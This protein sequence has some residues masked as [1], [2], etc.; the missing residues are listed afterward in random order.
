MNKDHLKIANWSAD[1][2][3]TIGGDDFFV[4]IVDQFR[5]IA[6]FDFCLI[7]LYQKNKP[8]KVIFDGLTP[9]GCADG[10]RNFVEN[11]YV[12]NPFYKAFS[13]G[14]DAGLHYMDE[15][16][17]GNDIYEGEHG[18]YK[19]TIDSAEEIGYVTRGWPK[20]MKEILISIPLDDN[21]MVEVTLAQKKDVADTGE[22]VLSELENLI[23]LLIS[24]VKKHCEIKPVTNQAANSAT[25]SLSTREK[26]VAELILAGHSSLS[27][28]NHLGIALP[29]VKTHRKN[30]YQKLEISTQAELFSIYYQK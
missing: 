8:P 11:T 28:G 13:K 7:F 9:I 20:H 21:S 2:V 29:T 30:I 17:N 22:R 1:F 24:G 5:D 16:I 18:D 3:A 12:L 4:Q 25:L 23:P 6:D 10:I 14:I 27:I 15:L 19:I 26:Q